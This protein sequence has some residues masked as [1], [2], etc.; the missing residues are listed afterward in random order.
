METL[1]CYLRKC[2]VVVIV[3]HGTLSARGQKPSQKIYEAAFNFTYNFKCPNTAFVNELVQC[4]LTVLD[5]NRVRATVQWQ[6]RPPFSHQFTEV[7]LLPLGVSSL[8]RYDGNFITCS[9]PSTITYG[10]ITFEYGQLRS[11]SIST[12]GAYIK[13]VVWITPYRKSQIQSR[14]IDDPCNLFK[15][16]EVRVESV[17]KMKCVKVGKL[18]P[19]ATVDSVP[20]IQLDAYLST[21]IHFYGSFTQEG[22]H[23]VVAVLEPYAWEQEATPK[24]IVLPIN[25][26]ASSAQSAPPSGP[27]EP[28]IGGIAIYEIVGSKLLSGCG[29]RYDVFNRRSRITFMADVIGGRVKEVKWCFKS[30]QNPDQYYEETVKGTEYTTDFVLAAGQYTIIAVAN[31]DGG[32]SLQASRFFEVLDSEDL[33]NAC[34]NYKRRDIDGS[35]AV[36]PFP[37]VWPMRLRFEILHRTGNY[38]YILW[39]NQ[40][41]CLTPRLRFNPM[42]N[43]DPNEARSHTG[44]VDLSVNNPAEGRAF[45][46]E[47]ANGDICMPAAELKLDAVYEVTV[48]ANTST[49]IGRDGHRIRLGRSVGANFSIKVTRPRFTADTLVIRA[50]EHVVLKGAIDGDNDFKDAEFRWRCEVQCPNGSTWNVSE[51]MMH[52]TEGSNTNTL[53]IFPEFIHQL[54]NQGQLDVCTSVTHPQLVNLQSCLTLDIW[55]PTTCYRCSLEAPNFIHEFQRVCVRCT[56]PPIQGKFEFYAKTKED[57]ITLG[58]A[59]NPSFCCMLPLVEGS[60]QMCIRSLPTSSLYIDECFRNITFIRSTPDEFE[61]QM[62]DILSGKSNILG[63]SIASK[64]PNTI[65]GTVQAMCAQIRWFVN[66]DLAQ[67]LPAAADQKRN[68]IAQLTEKLVGTLEEVSLANYEHLLPLSSGLEA[69]ATVA[70]EITY[71]TMNRI[72]SKLVEAASVL[73]QLLSHS[74]FQD[75]FNLA[76]R[77]TNMGV[78]LLEGMRHQHERPTPSLKGVRTQELVYETDIDTDPV[79]S[80]DALVLKHIWK[81]QR[82][83]AK[84]ITEVLT[85]INSVLADSLHEVLVPGG[86]MFQANFSTGDFVRFCRVMTWNLSNDHKACGE[87]NIVIPN[88]MDLQNHK[89][90]VIRTSRF[91]DNIYPFFNQ[92]QHNPRSSL[93]SLTFYAEGTALNLSDTQLSFRF[94]LTKSTP[95]SG[96]TNS[97]VE[98]DEQE[99]QLPEP[100]V[101]VDGTLIHQLL[102]MHR[103]EVDQEEAAFVFQLHPTD[104]TTCPQYL[105]VARFTVPPNLQVLDDYGSFYWAM[106]PSSTSICKNVSN[107]GE[108][109]QIYSLHIHS[110]VLSRLKVEAFTRTRHLKMRAEDL[111]LFYIG[112]RQL[113]ASELNHYDERNPPPVPYPFRDQINALAYVSAIVPSCVYIT[114]GEDTWNTSGCKVVPSF[115]ADEILCECTHLTTFA[116]GVTPMFESAHFKYIL[117]R[118]HSMRVSIS[119]FEVTVAIASSI[120]LMV[121]VSGQR[122]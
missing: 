113:S 103:F 44:N 92:D 108:R 73:P 15:G 66:S 51:E 76:R 71:K 33:A 105:V 102:I 34:G 31:G 99:V 81:V 45:E 115:K 39:N 53:V 104:T 19:Q 5:A 38:H 18:H 17:N 7:N 62:T 24:R 6:G 120:L 89:D 97:D 29:R 32:L 75:V 63:Q 57:H 98:F 79:D 116:A 43:S 119:A 88:I 59:E 87:S 42:L 55:S 94:T 49:K 56:C 25:V 60:I 122:H 50:P 36:W 101:A 74:S 4:N 67:S 121:F 95:A 96:F 14:T 61:E 117:Q 3:I 10:P 77:F 68:K 111:N 80:I 91:A 41:I 46:V 20:A 35:E 86:S 70:G 110:G 82:L 11:I 27:R 109:Q 69:I 40:S 23:S 9:P 58:I 78:F 100:I 112:Y 47:E 2:L 84:S 48:Y 83:S 8:K 64:D 72:H 114:P 12:D 30:Q 54:P 1:F 37:E 52:L 107:V 85:H 26:V 28:T 118:E 21:T 13:F 90:V 22:V 65:S 106:L 93:V 16:D